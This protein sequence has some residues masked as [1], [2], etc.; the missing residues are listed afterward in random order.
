MLQFTNPRDEAI[1]DQWPSGSRRVTAIFSLETCKR[2][3]RCSRVTTGKPKK[4][5]YYS[6]MKICDGGD[7]RIYLLASTEY[8]QRVVIPGTL[9]GCDYYY[10]DSS[11]GMFNQISEILKG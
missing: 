11:P 3:V 7:G 8:G 2:G 10:V 1:V 6:R 9:Q 4:T 5:T